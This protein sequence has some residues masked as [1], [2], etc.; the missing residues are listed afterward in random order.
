MKI[1]IEKF[2]PN[3]DSASKD[4]ILGRVKVVLGEKM[5][6][7]L[8]VIQGKNGSFVKFPSIMINKEFTAAIGWIGQNMEARI[9]EAIMEE[10]ESQYL[11][12]KY[13]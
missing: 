6:I 11:S 4:K 12:R 3:F 1:T 5:F 8:T 9:R 13:F 2:E 7:W 10:L